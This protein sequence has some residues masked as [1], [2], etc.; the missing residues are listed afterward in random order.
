[1]VMI[2]FL[3]VSV[4][5]YLYLYGENLLIFLLIIVPFVSLASPADSLSQTGQ[6]QTSPG[7]G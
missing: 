6:R 5:D 7:A 2:T 3:G 1:M 4:K